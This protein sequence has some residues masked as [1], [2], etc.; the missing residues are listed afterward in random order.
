MK[1]EFI[2]F[3]KNILPDMGMCDMCM[4]GMCMS[5]CAMRKYSDVG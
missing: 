4:Q 5:C 1:K 2:L 3:S